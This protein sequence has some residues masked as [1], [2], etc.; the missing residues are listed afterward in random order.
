MTKKEKRRRRSEIITER[1]KIQKPLEE[2]IVQVEDEIE[3]H[4]KELNELNDA[5]MEATQAQDGKRIEKISRSIH[6]GQAAIDRLFTELEELTTN[7]EKQAVIFEERLSELEE[8]A[9]DDSL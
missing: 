7:L 6:R 8:L 2:R 4:E 9:D 1:S 3:N 5:M